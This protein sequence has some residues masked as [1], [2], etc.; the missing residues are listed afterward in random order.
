MRSKNQ[1]CDP[2]EQKVVQY[3]SDIPSTAEYA[4]NNVYLVS[5]YEMTLGFILQTYANRYAIVIVKGT[6]F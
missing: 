2:R 5:T 3:V 4:L 1:S 6:R